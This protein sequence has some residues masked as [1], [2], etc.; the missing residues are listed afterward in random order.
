MPPPLS[1][2]RELGTSLR[3]RLK[4]LIETR[5]FLTRHPPEEPFELAS[6]EK[7]WIYFDC[8]TVTQDP[9]ALNL[10]ANLILELISSDDVDAVGG[11]ESGAI[12]ISTAVSMLSFQKGHP[13][14]S[15]WVRHERKTRGTKNRVE[16]GLKPN[17]RVVVI[18]DV[19]TKGGSVLDAVEVV[20]REFGCKVVEIITMVD[21]EEGARQRF[22]EKGIRFAPLFSKSEFRKLTE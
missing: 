16:G 5:A 1:S 14:P 8:K 13:L 18:D 10:I 17:S 4:Q 7:S 20:Q 11:L 6:G 15:F 21:R 3:G 12:P 22:K 2:A 19:T 9:E